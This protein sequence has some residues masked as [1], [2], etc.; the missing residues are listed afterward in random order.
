MRIDLK[1]KNHFYL[2]G[3]EA[4]NEAGYSRLPVD[5]REK[6][7]KINEDVGYLSTNSAGISAR[8]IT[9]SKE[10]RAKVVL[11]ASANMC[12]MPATG[13][14][15]IDLYVFDRIEQRYNF[16]AVT[17]YDETLS[18][19]EADIMRFDD[20]EERNV[21]INLPLYMGVK[22]IELIFDEGSTVIPDP[23]VKKE[24]ILVYGTSIAQG[25]CVSRPGMAYTNMLARYYNMEVINMGF[26]GS[27]FCESEVAIELSKIKG[28]SILIIDA[29]ANAGVD[30]RMKENLELF[31]ETYIKIN[32]EIKIIL[33]S[34]IKFAFDLHS[35]ERSELNKMYREWLSDLVQNN[36]Y[37]NEIYYLDLYDTFP[38]NFTEYTVDGVHP[39]DWGS[40]MI[41]EKYKEILDKVL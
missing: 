16:H 13:Q 18:E 5:S 6:I 20:V 14:C 27:A 10:I 41:F 12:H 29:E 24:K 9:N 7:S 17:K 23:I 21:W 4:L 35:T 26:S 11:D 28:Q 25:A 1:N 32:P 2:L 33:A 22:S 40:V 37:P 19:Y 36:K 30:M 39:S 34:R 38:D 3:S 15:G 31:I 8:F